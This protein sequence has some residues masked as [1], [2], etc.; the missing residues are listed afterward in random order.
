MTTAEYI[1]WAYST[2]WSHRLKP[3]LSPISG[4][5]AWINSERYTIQ[6][7]ADE[8]TSP[9]VMQGPMLQSLLKE[10]FKARIRLEVR[11]VLVYALIVAKGGFKG[12]PEN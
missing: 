12:E 9:E 2:S 6:A 10:R 11:Q 7:K 3:D 8:G 4:G 5:P 1:R